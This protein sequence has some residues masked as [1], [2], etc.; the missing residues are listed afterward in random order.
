M[1]RNDSKKR[2]ADVRPVD[3]R[4]NVRSG[5]SIRTRNDEMKKLQVGIVSRTE[6]T[7]LIEYMKDGVTKR[8]HI[9]AS[10]VITNEGLDP[11]VVDMGVP[12]GIP[13]ETI[14]QPSPVTGKQFENAMHV[15]GIWTYEEMISSPNVILGILQSLYGE[16]IGSLIAKSKSYRR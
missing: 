8:C 5:E 3:G 2:T 12:Y 11:S 7:I 16:D 13:F 4:K 14:F 9:P 6:N 15:N 1:G 10:V